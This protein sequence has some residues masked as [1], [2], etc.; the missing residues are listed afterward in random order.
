MCGVVLSGID[1]SPMNAQTLSLFSMLCAAQLASAGAAKEN[2][3]SEAHNSVVSHIPRQQVR[4]S[5][6]ASIGYSK[7]RHILEIQF[8]N[9][10]V[11]RYLEVAPSVYRELMFADSKARYYDNR[12]KGNY[13]SL[14][15]RSRP[16]K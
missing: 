6:I 13:L 4:S 3:R 16:K 8:V 15:V 14:K 2:I 10:A 11:Y 9:G 1:R 5:A 12:I 7:R